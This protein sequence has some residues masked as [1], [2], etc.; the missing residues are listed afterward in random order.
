MLDSGKS[1]KLTQLTL[2]SDTAGFTAIIK[3][4]QSSTGRFARV[5]GA[6]MVGSRTTFSLHGAA[7]RYYLVWITSLPSGG[8]AHV[9][10]VTAKT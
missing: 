3:S 4:S 1:Q 5:S 8:V 7:A 2:T 6:E 10:E 9:N